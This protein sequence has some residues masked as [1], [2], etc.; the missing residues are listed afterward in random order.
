MAVEQNVNVINL[1][2]HKIKGI[3][4]RS[5]EINERRSND[6]SR[7]TSSTYLVGV[8]RIE[9]ELEISIF[10]VIKCQIE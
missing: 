9:N 10:K 7:T 2:K 1:D 5:W 6:K 3:S 8:W 4:D